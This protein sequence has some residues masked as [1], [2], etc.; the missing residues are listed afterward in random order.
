MIHQLVVNLV[1][2]KWPNHIGNLH[3][4]KKEPQNYPFNFFKNNW[5]TTK[6]KNMSL[7]PKIGMFSS[8]MVF[9]WC[10]LLFPSL[11]CTLQ[12]VLYH[13]IKTNPNTAISKSLKTKIL[14]YILYHID[15]HQ[16]LWSL[17]QDTCTFW[18][19]IFIKSLRAQ[20]KEPSICLLRRGFISS[21]LEPLRSI[22]SMPFPSVDRSWVKFRI[23]APP[24]NDCSEPSDLRNFRKFMT[25]TWGLQGRKMLICFLT[26]FLYLCWT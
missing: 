4:T 8:N 1:L 13:L 23:T 26:W 12:Q 25:M 7:P 18:V 19:I 6:K 21:V 16:Q 20:Q 5:N 22:P 14:Y 9:L 17:F 24:K 11:L 15:L 3:L 2:I 10:L